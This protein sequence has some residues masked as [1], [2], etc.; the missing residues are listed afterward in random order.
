MI[1]IAQP[2]FSANG[3][4]AQSLINLA[5]IIGRQSNIIYLVSD[6]LG[7][8]PIEKAKNEIKK[9]G[10]VQSF[11][12]NSPS[13]RE[14]TLKVLN[15]LK[16]LLVLKPTINTVFFLDAHLVLLSLLWPF[17]C[18]KNI[19]KLGV[20]YLL[21]PE[22]IARYFFI[23][24]LI[25]HFLKRKEVLLF[26]RTNEPYAIAKIA[27]IKLCESYNRQY[28]VDYR[29]VMPTNLYGPNDNFHPKNSHVV[30]A[31]IKRIYEAKLSNFPEVVIWGSGKQKREF[32]Y[33]DDMAAASIYLMGINQKVFQSKTE[34]MISHV[35]IGTGHDCTIRELV[36]VIAH[37]IGYG[38]EVVFDITKPDGPP[39]KLLNVSLMESLNW[40]ASATLESGVKKTY[41][42]FL[43]HQ[44]EH[45][46]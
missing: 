8:K 20:V 14:G 45:R 28:G 10:E 31:L 46:V 24:H 34:S 21:G 41:E 42:W 7:N 4:P 18:S 17:F 37:V 26:L 13:V 25:G 9:L 6:M 40:K 35:N 19:K 27:G 29:S 22:K 11:V 32:L 38:G 3:H 44:F 16:K 1:V 2:W 23:K 15:A 30:P 12:V 5:K 39:R 43:A 33:V 36:K